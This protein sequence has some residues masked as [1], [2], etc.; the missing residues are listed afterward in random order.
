MPDG[1]RRG[2][3]ESHHCLPDQLIGDDQFNLPFLHLLDLTA[4]ANE[5][6]TALKRAEL[7][8]AQHLP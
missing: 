8:L 5:R 4:L 7:T 2:G 6:L 1:R 3:P